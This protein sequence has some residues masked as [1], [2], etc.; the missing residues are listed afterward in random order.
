MFLRTKTEQLATIV[1]S[2]M[3]EEILSTSEQV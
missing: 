3:D 1:G 2:H